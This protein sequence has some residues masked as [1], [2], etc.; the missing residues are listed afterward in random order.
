MEF[1]KLRFLRVFALGFWKGH[2]LQ[3]RSAVSLLGSSGFH[4]NRPRSN[5][6][7]NG[8]LLG[9]SRGQISGVEVGVRRLILFL[10]KCGLV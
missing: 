10:A 8:A 4:H 1:P 2:S 5:Y 6:T 9:L 7:H 3:K